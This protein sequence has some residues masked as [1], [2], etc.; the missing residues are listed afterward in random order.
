MEFCGGQDQGPLLRMSLKHGLG[1]A[2][3]R[4]SFVVT[5]AE[6][7]SSMGYRA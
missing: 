4:V 5:L 2:G 3:T 6:L 1:G 7:P